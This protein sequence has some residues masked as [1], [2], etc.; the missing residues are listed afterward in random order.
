MVK[1][2]Y[3]DGIHYDNWIL[4]S[5]FNKNILM[6]AEASRGLPSYRGFRVGTP[7][8]LHKDVPAWILAIDEC[9]VHYSETYPPHIV[10]IFTVECDV[11]SP[12]Y[13]RRS[14]IKQGLTEDQYKELVLAREL[15]K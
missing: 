14:D 11:V 4:T 5:S 10:V 7:I 3:N 6:T 1:A 13:C 15:Q 2:R 9:E 8:L 12:T